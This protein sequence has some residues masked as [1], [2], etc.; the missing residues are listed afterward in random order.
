MDAAF[1]PGIELARRYY[2]EVVRPLLDRLVPG[3][4]HSAGLIG[5]G[6][7]V[8][9]FDSRRSADHNWGPRCQV[10][11]A[12]DDASRAPDVSA[13][14]AARLPET[15]LGWRTRFPDVT[16][17]G[18]PV[19][20]WVEVAGLG[21]WLAGRLGFDPRQGVTL[22]DW[23]STPTQVLA[24][25]TSG[26]V[27][28]DGLDGSTEGGLRTMCA[29]LDWYPDDVWRYLLACQWARIGQEEAFPGRCAEAGD[30]LGSAVVTAR[31]VRD[32]MRLVL[33][34][35]RRYPPYSKWLGTAFAR[36]PVSDDLLPLLLA[37]VTATSWPERE[38][39]MRGAYEI[40][41][42]L[43]NSLAL[44][45]P[46]DARVRPY[47]DRPYLVIDAQRFVAPLRDSIEADEIRRLPLTGAVDQFIDNTDAAGEPQ[48]LRA[49][50]RARLAD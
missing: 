29:V 2:A 17:A 22:L 11:V 3:L 23:L 26:E 24:E 25:V 13:A 36:L 15:F 1:V 10:F 18:F 45:D 14:L 27:F 50:I 16:V 37:A 47:Y 12:P 6:S 43:H 44:T 5:A 46:L 41:G 8:L 9:G 4:D 40:V 33:L 35:Q 19:R 32:M 31:L 20:H 7:E 39:L 48:L 38:Q 42:Q 34:T 28:H 30:E 21:G 49:A